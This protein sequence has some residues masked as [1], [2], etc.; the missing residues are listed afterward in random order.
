[1]STSLK[2]APTDADIGQNQGVPSFNQPTNVDN[3]PPPSPINLPAEQLS[4]ITKIQNYLNENGFFT[5]VEKRKYSTI[6]EH[7]EEN[8]IEQWLERILLNRA[9][10]WPL[11]GA[12]SGCIR[13]IMGTIQLCF[14]VCHFTSMFLYSLAYLLALIVHLCT[15]SLNHLKIPFSYPSKSQLFFLYIGQHAFLNVFR[16][17]IEIIPFAGLGLKNFYDLKDYRMGYQ[18]LKTCP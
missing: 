8:N 13:M 7:E 3:P 16:G 9:G 14:A 10:Y 18:D 2:V 11:L 1:M 12:L 4:T 6:T 5:I 17:L 15:Q